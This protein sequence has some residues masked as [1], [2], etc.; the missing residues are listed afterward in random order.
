MVERPII[1]CVDDE[2]VVLRA[3]HGSLRSRLGRRCAI[4]M[5]SNG[6][7]ALELI[8]ELHQEQASPAVVISDAMMPVMDGY[9][10]VRWLYEHMPAVH[11]ILI[12]GYGD[13]TKIDRLRSDA[14]LMAALGKPWDSDELCALIEGAL[15]L[16]PD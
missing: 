4:E 2:P 6:A 8:E 12:T 16:G 5:A 15:G 10:L 1:L 3:M 9:A 11:T 7:E 14:G 13:Q